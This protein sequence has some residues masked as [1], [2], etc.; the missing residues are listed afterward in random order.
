MGR[1]CTNVD[2][3]RGIV[4]DVFI[5]EGGADGPYEFGIAMFTFVFGGLREDGRE[6]ME[7]IQLI[8]GNDHQEGKKLFPDG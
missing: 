2:D 7:A 3:C 5:V 6:R 8:K 4:G 1:L